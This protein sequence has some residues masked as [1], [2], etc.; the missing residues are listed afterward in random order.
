MQLSELTMPLD[1]PWKRAGVSAD[2][3]D[4]VGADRD[5][6]EKWRSSMAFFSHEPD[7]DSLPSEYCD[8][9]I[10]YLKVACTITNYQLPS[11]SLIPSLSGPE[12]EDVTVLDE[13]R[14][15]YA[16]FYAWKDFDAR[17]TDSYP[18]Y[19]AL[20]QVGIYP[21][22]ADGVALHD[23]PYISSIQ[24]RKREMYEVV[25]ESGEVAAQSGNKLNVL[26]GTTTTDTT[27]KYELDLGGRGYGW[28]FVQAAAGQHGNVTSNQTQDQSVTTVD[29]SREKR[30]SNAYS[31]SLNHIYSLLQSYH[32]GTNRAVFLLQ[33][34]P[35][36][37]DAHATFVRGI[38]RLEGVQEFFLIINRPR[39]VKGICIEAALET[40]HFYAERTYRPR[41]VTESEALRPENLDK[42]EEA[43]G[44]SSGGTSLP[45]LYPEQFALVETWNDQASSWG[46][47][48]AIGYAT[49]VNWV[50]WET[51]L[52]L[53]GSGYFTR[54]QWGD[55]VDVAMR[56]PGIKASD[57][58][59]LLFDKFESNTGKMF[60]TGRRLCTCLLPAEGDSNDGGSEG[61]EAS[62]PDD[63]SVESSSGDH[64][65]TCD[66]PPS[67]VFEKDLSPSNVVQGPELASSDSYAST[68]N[69]MSNS[70]GNELLASLGSSERV[71]YGSRS[72]LQSEFI[73]DELSQVVR[74]LADAGVNDVSAADV[75]AFKPLLGRGLGV[76]SGVHGVLG[77]GQMSTR[78]VARDLGVSSREATA[79]RLDML[80]H[81]LQALDLDRGHV[82][83]RRRDTILNKLDAVNAARQ[84]EAERRSPPPRTDD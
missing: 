41:L 45:S 68:V 19:G 13:M 53:I 61:D 36:I 10:T 77:L 25:T 58:V 20:L 28:N 81:A 22:P 67:I 44:T 78:A 48:L 17:V 9:R 65:S 69:D 33:P 56:T 54:D 60:V 15:K 26:K 21:N 66:E 64:L 16:D 7:P 80:R 46:H 3:I 5:F 35:R 31:T 6:P 83:A 50:G 47:L 55:L 39:A 79:V 71:S 27:E 12:K 51:V 84:M 8:R 40:A 29:A 49:Q 14:E 75:D 74:L 76:A 63:V 32:L 1:I 59:S 30:E 23:Y 82:D 70:I 37:Q 34:R 18:C 57:K 2:M 52:Q 43:I 4:E 42:T 73:M 72:F 11:F 62:A 24:P 38:R